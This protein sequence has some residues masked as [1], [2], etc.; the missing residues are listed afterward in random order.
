MTIR[1]TTKLEGSKERKK[2]EQV[3]LL[4]IINYLSKLLTEDIDIVSIRTG[5]APYKKSKAEFYKTMVVS[6][7]DGT[8]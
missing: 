6:A 1:D 3:L 5:E 7:Q 2:E 8:Q 4:V